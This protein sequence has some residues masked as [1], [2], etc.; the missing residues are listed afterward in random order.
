MTFWEIVFGP[1]GSRSRQNHAAGDN[2]GC[3][4]GIAR[5][6]LDNISSCR[7]VCETVLN[8]IHGIAANQVIGDGASPASSDLVVI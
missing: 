6:V 2:R 1:R 3:E 7:E 5:D 8:S 4:V